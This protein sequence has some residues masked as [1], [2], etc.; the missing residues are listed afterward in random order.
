MTEGGGPGP[1]LLLGALDEVAATTADGGALVLAVARA[2]LAHLDQ[3]SGAC[4]GITAGGEVAVL[5][6][7]SAV[8]AVAVD[9]GQEVQLTAVARLLPVNRTFSGTTSPS[10]WP[11]APQATPTPGSGWT[12]ASCTRAASW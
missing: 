4:A 6:H 3:V 5:V 8:A 10:G 12:A 11:S 9:G 1:D 7:G 2:M